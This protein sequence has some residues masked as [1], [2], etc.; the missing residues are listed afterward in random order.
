M[1]QGLT[2][3]EPPKRMWG[4]LF[5]GIYQDPQRFTEFVASK[6]VEVSP[7][8]CLLTE[9]I[10]I[11]ICDFKSESLKTGSYNIDRLQR[12]PLSRAPAKNS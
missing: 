6:I 11:K 5:H 9:L 12:K 1:Q 7:L 10:R 2:N 3:R 4:R 8:A